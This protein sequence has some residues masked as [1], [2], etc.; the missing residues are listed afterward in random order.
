MNPPIPVHV[1]RVDPDN[2]RDVEDVME[3]IAFSIVLSRTP[4]E[5]WWQEFESAYQQL[6]HPIKPQTELEGDRIWVTYL[7]RYEGELQHYVD[8]VV[9]VVDKANVEE[10]LTYDMHL[11]GHRYGPREQFRDSLR[12]VTIQPASK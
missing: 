6:P 1:V 10:Q 11:K 8:F 2:L 4:N 9:R 12:K 7:P 5:A 3:A